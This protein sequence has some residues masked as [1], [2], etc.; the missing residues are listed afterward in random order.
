MQE[1]LASVKLVYPAYPAAFYI[2]MC[3]HTY[4]YH[5]HHALPWIHILVMWQQGMEVIMENMKYGELAQCK[6]V[7]RFKMEYSDVRLDP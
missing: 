2:K 3:I 5:H 6:N 1:E 4:H 7:T